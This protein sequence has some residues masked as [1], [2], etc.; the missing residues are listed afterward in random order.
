ML[1]LSP[2]VL[3]LLLP[4]NSGDLGTFVRGVGPIVLETYIE[5]FFFF[6]V[7]YS[8]DIQEMKEMWNT[9]ATTGSAWDSFTNSNSM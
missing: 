7:S 5:S 8:N 2:L 3:I 9:Y 4:F 6:F 1:F